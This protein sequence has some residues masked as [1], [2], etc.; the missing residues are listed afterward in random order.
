MKQPVSPKSTVY[1]EIA[2]QNI[3]VSLLY[4]YETASLSE[5]CIGK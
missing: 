3:Y 4:T 2:L 1:K 5:K